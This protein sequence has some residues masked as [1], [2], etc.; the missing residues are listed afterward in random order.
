LL[1]RWDCKALFSGRLSL[2]PKSRKSFAQYIQHDGL[3]LKQR[4]KETM[5]ET[6]KKQPPGKPVNEEKSIKKAEI[7]YEMY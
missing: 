3:Y 7:M 4:G 1:R 5:K 6:M 2:D